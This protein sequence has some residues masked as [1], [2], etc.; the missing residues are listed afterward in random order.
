MG[1]II[2]LDIGGS[3]IAGALVNMEAGLISPDS[4]QKNHLDTRADKEIIIGIW[5]EVIKSIGKKANYEPVVGI[6]IAMPG[7]FDYENGI[8]WIKGLAKYDHLYGVNIKEALI[9]SLQKPDDFSI[10]FENDAICFALGECASGNASGY[11]NVVALTLGT[12]FGAAFIRN[13]QPVQSGPDVPPGGT[14][15]Q[16]PFEDGLAEDC[17]SGRGLCKAYALYSGVKLTDAKVI[18]DRA[19]ANEQDALDVFEEFGKKLARF[20]LPWLRS[21]DADCLVLGGS[22]S[23]AANFFMPALKAELDRLNNPLRV[24]LTRWGDQAAILG[25]ATLIQNKK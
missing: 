16:E 8:S 5:T 19:M 18:Y 24:V 14:L 15:Y 11:N 23:H 7:P 3:H 22:I 13:R 21:F 17:F 6:G 20:L 10:R 2:G 1:F 25:A 9:K 4:Y 12:G